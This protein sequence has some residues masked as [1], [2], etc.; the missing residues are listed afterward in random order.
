MKRREVL[1]ASLGAALLAGGVPEPARAKTVLSRVRPGGAGWPSAAEWDGLRRATSGR[2]MPLAPPFAG[3]AA[4]AAACAAMRE[5]LKNPYFVGDNPA[6]TQT[7]GW[8]DAWLSQPSAYAVAAR[9]TADIVA[10]V[11]FARTHK[12]RLVVKGG[13][14][15]YKGGSN[16]PDS[17]LVWPRAMNEVTVIDAFVPQGGKGSEAVPAVSVGAGAMWIDA[18]TAVTT[19]AGR[20]V[21]GGGCTTVGVPGLVQGGG[22]GSFSKRYGTAAASLLEAEIVT[23]DGQ[24]RI[25]NAYTNPDLFWAI[26]GGGGGSFGVVTRMTL[27][28]HELPEFFGGVFGEITADSDAAFKALVA[29]FVAFYHERLFNPH[30]GETVSLREGRQLH[31]SMVFQGLSGAEAKALWAPFLDWVRASEDY[32]FKEPTIMAVPARRFWDGDFWSKT[33][34]GIMAR[35]ER[36]GAPAHHVVWQGDRGQVGWYIHGYESTWL[37]ASL[38]DEG[39]Q[40]RLVDSLC[41]A[42]QQWWVELHFNKGIAGAPAQA[43]AATRATSSHPGVVDAFALAIIAGGG[44]AAYPGMPGAKVDDKEAQRRAAKIRRAM[45]LLRKAAPDA[46]AYVS[47]SDFFQQRWQDAYWGPNYPKLLKIKQRYDPDGLFT[48]RHGV[49]SE[50]WSVD[51]FARKG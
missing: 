25:A 4:D 47:E 20:Y 21:Q 7:S 14:H 6:L 45:D 10:A 26:K 5:Q 51:G 49:G 31:L 46:G 2:L 15:S 23:A 42:S 32:N 17:L 24:A 1:K 41:A 43:L 48:V 28:T 36:E 44:D 11:N 16:A 39:A 27:R 35:D 29:R 8:Q 18:Y 12:L 34:P 22:F 38:L 33:A 19:K 30:W 13:G 40:A 50:D 3:C 9:E 37:P